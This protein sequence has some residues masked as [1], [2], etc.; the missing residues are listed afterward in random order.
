MQSNEQPEIIDLF[1]HYEQ[2][3][4]PVQKLI[5][6]EVRGYKQCEKLLKKLEAF[7]YTFDYGLDGCPI[8]LRK[9]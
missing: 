1:E 3:P 5:F 6:K 7:G 9:I 4:K 2:L 8:D